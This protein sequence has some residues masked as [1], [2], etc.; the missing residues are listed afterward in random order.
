MK[1]SIKAK[2][3]FFLGGLF[4][5]LCIFLGLFSVKQLT[6]FSEKLIGEQ[7]L[8]IVKSFVYQIDGDEFRAASKNMEESKEYIEKMNALMDSIKS[9]T[10]CTYLYAM[11]K[12]TDIEYMYVLSNDG[13]V[14]TT[15]DVSSYNAIFMNSMNRGDIGYTEIEEDPEYGD[16]LSAVVPIKDSKGEIVGILACDF[17][18]TTVAKKI[19]YV[20][21]VM[22]ALSIIILII[23]CVITYFAVRLLFKRLN[24]IIEATNEVAEGNLNITID[25]SLPDE[26]GHLAANFNQMI[27]KL[28]TLVSDIKQMT[29]VIDENATNLSACAEEACASANVAGDSIELIAEGITA[30]VKELNHV[31]Q[32]VFSFGE[33]MTQMS[34][35]VEKI[36][37]KA[38]AVSK[39]SN[40]GTTAILQMSASAENVGGTFELVKNK[41]LDLDASIQKIAEMTE[42]IKSIASQTKLLALNASIEAARAG[43]AGKGFAVVA[44]EIKSLS[45]M[46]KKSADEIVK[47]VDGISFVTSEAMEGFQSLDLSIVEQMQTSKESLDVLKAIINEVNEIIPQIEEI[48]GQALLLNREKDEVI[49]KIKHSSKISREIQDSSDDVH[50]ASKEIHTASEDVASSAEVLNNLTSGIIQK[51]DTFKL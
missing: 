10:G 15:E 29:V 36:V 1:V 20:K 13:E 21:T 23:S 25:D 22:I 24:S 28:H 27:G 4:S 49:A 11:S 51:V 5:V 40:E 31:E 33:N 48:S 42:L 41:I 44:T 35:N 32:F 18:A 16:M 43:E 8:S 34:N 45:D 12:V 2:S 47:K 3:L 9:D 30:Q 17:L 37:N 14:G 38:D 6:E 26:F 50:I 46:T 7:A 39:K 19:S